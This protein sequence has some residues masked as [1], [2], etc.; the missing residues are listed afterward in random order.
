MNLMTDM[1]ITE[2]GYLEQDVRKSLLDKPAIRRIRLSD[3]HGVVLFYATVGE[4]WY[5]FGPKFTDG[6]MVDIKRRTKVTPINI[7]GS[8]YWSEELQDIK[9]TKKK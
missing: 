8:C 2:D 7:G 5:E 6:K 4:E 1:Y 3:I 9:Y